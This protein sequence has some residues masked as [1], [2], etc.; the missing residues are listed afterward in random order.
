M[1]DTS[2]QQPPQSQAMAQSSSYLRPRTPQ[3]DLQDLAT[4]PLLDPISPAGPP[5]QAQ[6]L[7]A[8]VPVPL[9][10]FS[11]TPQL[12]G[13]HGKQHVSAFASKPS[14]GAAARNRTPSSSSSDSGHSGPGPSQHSQSQSS[15][16]LLDTGSG[17]GVN[18]AVNGNEWTSAQTPKSRSA[19]RSPHRRPR[20]RS[21]G[22]SAASRG[23]NSGATGTGSVVGAPS[24]TTT[25]ITSSDSSDPSH[26]A[27]RPNHIEPTTSS[28]QFSPVGSGGGISAAQFQF[29]DQRFD[30]FQLP[31]DSPFS[32]SDMEQ[33]APPSL[34][35]PPPPTAR[36]NAG[37]SAVFSDASGTEYQSVA[38]LGLGPTF[39]GPSAVDDSCSGGGGGYVAALA[40]GPSSPPAAVWVPNIQPLMSA[41]SRTLPRNT[42]GQFVALPG[43]SNGVMAAG[44]ISRA[45]AA[46]QNTQS[47][48]YS[49]VA[50]GQVLEGYV[51][52]GG[53]QMDTFGGEVNPMIQSIQSVT[54][55]PNANQSP[56]LTD[57]R[58]STLNPN[59][60]PFSVQ[61]QST[62]SH[63][64]YAH[65]MLRFQ[66]P[67]A[68]FSNANSNGFASASA[69][70]QLHPTSF[71]PAFFSN[72]LQQFPVAIPLPNPSLPPPLPRRQQLPPSAVSTADQILFQL[73]D[74]VSAFGA[75]PPR[76]RIDP[77]RVCFSLIFLL[78]A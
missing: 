68:V 57:A 58:G 65:P 75:A 11:K 25:R 47:T 50:P 44:T 31:R 62:S 41:P 59:Q 28:P 21:R 13:G 4:T 71:P 2:N 69:A 74:S 32:P 72:N 53:P 36:A 26:T 48:F 63:D 7:P 73:T 60:S 45:R 22:A 8:Q 12:G 64:P 20:R 34:V 3:S 29:G 15:G 76:M 42:S 17:V 14:R 43:V 67:N 16:P 35:F 66:S 78:F 77:F 56:P 37:G 38:E 51:Y 70:S 23:A 40:F 1:T 33:R 10:P 27:N 18:A 46:P 9:P 30:Q 61:S 52:A 24:G 54:Y 39:I 55:A 6:E 19:R 5:Q 49:P